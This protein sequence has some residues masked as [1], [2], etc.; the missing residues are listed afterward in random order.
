MRELERE[1]KEG[2]ILAKG[3]E[4]RQR[5]QMATVSTNASSITQS[6]GNPREI[7]RRKSEE[8]KERKTQGR[9][10]ARRRGKGGR[11]AG[12]RM[13]KKEKKKKERKEG[14]KERRKEKKRKK[15]G[16]GRM[17]GYGLPAVAGGGRRWPEKAAKALK[18]QA[19]VVQV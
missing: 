4:E 13:E 18:T 17:A 1:Q 12:N 6:I 5:K 15:K 3:V 14:R 2:I 19:K 8:K 7:E 11:D 9:R 10:D 16:R